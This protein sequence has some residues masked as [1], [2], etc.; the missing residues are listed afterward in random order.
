MTREEKERRRTEEKKHEER[1]VPKSG[2]KKQIRG[3][4]LAR[5]GDTRGN[6]KME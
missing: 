6:G 3:K 1:E 4:R 5:R 2:Q